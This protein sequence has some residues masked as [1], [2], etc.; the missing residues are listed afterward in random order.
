MSLPLIT[1]NAVVAWQIEI[2]E[3]QGIDRFH[4]SNGEMVCIRWI[5]GQCAHGQQCHWR[6]HMTVEKD[7][8]RMTMIDAPGHPRSNG[9]ER[10]SSVG[11]E[12]RS[13]PGSGRRPAIRSRSPPPQRPSA[14][15]SRSSTE[16]MTRTAER[17]QRAVERTHLQVYAVERRPEVLTRHIIHLARVIAGTTANLEEVLDRGDSR[18]PSRRRH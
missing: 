16:T 17:V 7:A 18:S 9:S 2:N 15:G 1:L 5:Q 14:R 3:M 12:A 11:T 6:H 13:R 8:M 4:H 10:P